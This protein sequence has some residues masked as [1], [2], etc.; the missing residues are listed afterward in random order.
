VRWAAAEALPDECA[1]IAPLPQLPCALHPRLRGPHREAPRTARPRDLDL[2]RGVGARW[3]AG[4]D[5]KKRT[6][7]EETEPWLTG[8]SELVKNGLPRALQF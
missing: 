1:N 3:T 8:K 4:G 2:V 7:E 5:N 6:S